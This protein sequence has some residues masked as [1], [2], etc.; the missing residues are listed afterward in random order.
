MYDDTSIHG[1]LFVVN[2]RYKVLQI[3]FVYFVN[4]ERRCFQRY[5]GFLEG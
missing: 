1:R 4:N 2:D 3:L 5:G